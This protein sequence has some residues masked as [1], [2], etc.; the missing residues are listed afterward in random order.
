MDQENYHSES[1]ENPKAKDD[2]CEF[3]A[4]AFATALVNGYDPECLIF[5]QS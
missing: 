4:A 5:D 2:L 3:F 1:Y